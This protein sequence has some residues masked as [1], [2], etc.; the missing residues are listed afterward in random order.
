M[1]EP[2]TI[3]FI[4]RLLVAWIT[5]Y[6]T[7]FHD[8]V[9]E[10]FVGLIE[11]GVFED[12]E[13]QSSSCGSD[14]GDNRRH[15]ARIRKRKHALWVED[16]QH[17]RE[18]DFQDLFRINRSILEHIVAGMQHYLEPIV[19]RSILTMYTAVLIP[20]KYLASGI[21]YVDISYLFGISKTLCHEVVDVFLSHF[22]S[23]FKAAWVRFPTREELPEMAREFAAVKGVPAVV[24]AVDG[25]HIHMKG[26]EGHRTEYWTRKSAYA[27]QLQVTCDARGRIWD[28]L[29]GYPGSADDMRVFKESALLERLQNGDIAPY[30]IVGDAAYPLREY[31]L[32]PLHA[33][34]GEDL[35]DDW[36]QTFNYCQSATRMAVE[37]CIGA[38]KGR[39]RIFGQRN[40]CRLWRLLAGAACKSEILRHPFTDEA[41]DAVHSV[42]MGSP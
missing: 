27:V 4:L 42:A 13:E 38:F 14:Y 1:A 34:R 22:P 9:S 33:P 16:L 37:R 18:N 30:Q 32:T 29:I 20:I 2:R 8:N 5:Y 35:M 11:S 15:R 40:D 3:P 24:G 17:M 7:I 19:Q 12:D 23:V 6:Y 36:A 39:W 21:S 31:C 25:T 41:F 10:S 28:Y 26:M